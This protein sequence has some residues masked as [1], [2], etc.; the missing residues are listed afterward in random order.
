MSPTEEENAKAA[1]AARVFVPRYVRID[2]PDDAG[3]QKPSEGTYRPPSA[4]R[5]HPA[6]GSLPASQLRVRVL[7]TYTRTTAQP[8]QRDTRSTGQ[9]A[10]VHTVERASAAANAT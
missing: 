2:H 7:G 6:Q 8:E 10:L 5:L 3:P 9:T 1:T 4:G